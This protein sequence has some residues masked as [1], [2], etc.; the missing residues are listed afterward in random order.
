MPDFSGLQEAI[1]RLQRASVKLDHEKAK[2]EKKFRKV[3]RRLA[4]KCNR[5]RHSRFRSFV[6]HAFG[7]R[8]TNAMASTITEKREEAVHGIEKRGGLEHIRLGMAAAGHGSVKRSGDSE[9]TYV[10]PQVELETHAKQPWC[11]ALKTAGDVWSL[12]E[13]DLGR[14][15]CL[16]RKLAKARKAVV[17]VNSKL[18]GFERGFISSEGIQDREW[19]R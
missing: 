8:N 6:K 3:F 14:R 18:V 19:Y 2:V 9:E 16:L 4:N 13:A 15:G 5:R 7:V 17:K 12:D 11:S 1:R 10:T